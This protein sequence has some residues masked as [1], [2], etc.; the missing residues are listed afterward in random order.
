MLERKKEYLFDPK[1]CAERIKKETLRDFEKKINFSA[2]E[3]N[4]N[5]KKK[6]K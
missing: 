5:I 4:S 6:S 1:S 3:S 2:K